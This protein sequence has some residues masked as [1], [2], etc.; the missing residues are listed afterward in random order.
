[1]PVVTAK[2]R[3]VMTGRMIGSSP[4]QAEP[5]VIGW[6][7]GGFTG[8]VSDVA[9]FGESAELRITGSS[10]LT[11]TTTTNDTYQVTGT[12]VAT[13]ARTITAV[14]LSDTTS[15]PFATTV[16]G[17]TAVGSNSGTTLTVAASYTPA[18][19]TYVQIRTEVLQVTAGSGTTSLTVVRGAN[20]STPI[21]TIANSD[22][23][24][25][26]NPP[27]VSTVTN[28]N[29]I[30]HGEHGSTTLASGESIAYTVTVKVT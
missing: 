9:A 11:T 13:G 14:L 20:G 23:V 26:G 30:V 25:A 19:N 5:K 28:G 10:S 1:M 27:G 16:T 15:K 2:G 17:G 18:N 3:E 21:T 7:T 24:T 29:L 4:T 22:P 6:D 12:M 8:A